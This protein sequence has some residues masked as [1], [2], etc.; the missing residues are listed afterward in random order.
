MDVYKNKSGC[1]ILQPPTFKFSEKNCIDWGR[2]YILR[3]MQML[4]VDKDL[5]KS[6]WKVKCNSVWKQIPENLIKPF[7][8]EFTR[9]EI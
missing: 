7:K 2:M 8:R 5:K 3:N 9:E 4:I 1:R 6:F